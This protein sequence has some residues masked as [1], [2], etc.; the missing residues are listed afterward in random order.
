MILFVI[1]SICISYFDLIDM[2]SC[3]LK[4]ISYDG[5]YE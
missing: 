2:Y 3:I 4:V 5:I 1:C